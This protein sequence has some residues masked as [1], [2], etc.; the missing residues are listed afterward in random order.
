MMYYRPRNP[1]I[2]LQYTRVSCI[3]FDGRY[4]TVVASHQLVESGTTHLTYFSPRLYKHSRASSLN[5]FSVLFAVCK[6]ATSRQPINSTTWSTTNCRHRGLAPPSSEDL[7]KIERTRA[8]PTIGHDFEGRVLS[9]TQFTDAQTN[10]CCYCC[11]ICLVVMI[12]NS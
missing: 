2:L 6:L 12:T 4:V 8:N 10:C 1:C 3:S 7:E 11:C 9:V 5:L